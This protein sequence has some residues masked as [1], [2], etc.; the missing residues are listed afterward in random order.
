MDDS[1]N[2]NRLLM[3]KRNLFAT[4][5]AA[6]TGICMLGHCAP[7]AEE[8]VA[9][10]KS[11]S[12]E[13][14]AKACIGLSKELRF[15]S[16]RCISITNSGD[17]VACDQGARKAFMIAPEGEIKTTVALPVAPTVVCMINDTTLCVAGEGMI[18][19]ASL[20]GAIGRSAAAKEAG[21]PE[22]A[23]PSGI[24]ASG[25]DI[26]VAY[27]QVPGKS[28]SGA[29]YRLGTDLSGAK[30]ISSGHRGCCGNLAIGAHDGNVYIAENSSHRVAI[31]DRDGTVVKRWGER[32]RKSLKGFASCCNPMALSIDKNGTVY[33]S[34]SGPNRIKRY[35]SDGKFLGLVGTLGKEIRGTGKM[36]A[37]CSNTAVAVNADGSRVYVIDENNDL[38]RVLLAK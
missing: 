15:K 37:S 12:H 31:L 26:F 29:I 17:L 3:M 32:D 23:T 18:V 21:L 16:L 6:L 28:V 38:I 19:T 1:H 8:A 35:S 10:E 13:E 4:I 20:D 27:C 30:Q 2:L 25:D 7:A 9:D 22:T 5:T 34:E 11:A 36:A 14:S 24:A 33:T